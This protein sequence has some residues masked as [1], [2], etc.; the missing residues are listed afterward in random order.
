MVTEFRIYFE[1][2][3]QLTP[4]FHQFFTEIIEVARLTRCRVRLVATNGTP[5][6]DFRDALRTHPVAWNVL[7]LDSDSPCDGPLADLCRSKNLDSSLE[8]SIFWM[9]QIMESWFLADPDALKNYYD[10]DFREDAIRGDPQVERI[11]KS[12]VLSQLKRATRDTRRGRG[13]YH[14]TKH[15]PELLARID[16]DRVKKAAPNCER[17]FRFVL[18]KL[19]L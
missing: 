16:P 17:M 6:E 9:V 12:D 10:S 5:A 14:K 7:L 15:A 13:E 19:G 11:P 8:D 2:D 18:A 1:G 3:P 4:G